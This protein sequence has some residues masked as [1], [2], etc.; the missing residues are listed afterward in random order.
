VNVADL[1]MR[2]FKAAAAGGLA[3]ATVNSGDITVGCPCE[4]GP[5]W[6][7]PVGVVAST[8][9]KVRE[10]LFSRIDGQWALGPVENGWRAYEDPGVHPGEPFEVQRLP[11]RSR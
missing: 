6:K 3:K 8:A 4:G 1:E 9:F 11:S 2:E 7:D 5:R 10:L